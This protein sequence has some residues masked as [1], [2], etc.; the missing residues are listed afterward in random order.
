MLEEKELTP[1]E[2]EE[3]KKKKYEDQDINAPEIRKAGIFYFAFAIFCVVLTW[4]ILRLANP[5]ELSIES[6]KPEQYRLPE[7]G[8]RLQGNVATK[9]DIRTLRSRE[10]KILNSY[11]WIDQKKQIARIPIDR[12]I[13]LILKKGLPVKESHQQSGHIQKQSLSDTQSNQQN[14]YS[15]Q[16]ENVPNQTSEL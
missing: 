12:A 1:Q 13:A 9:A 10:S 14:S 2:I 5:D 7:S 6:A 15:E 11:E 4:F 3:L 16:T 8:P